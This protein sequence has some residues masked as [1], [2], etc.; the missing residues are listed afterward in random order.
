MYPVAC[1]PQAWASAAGFA[2]VQACLGLQFAPD[3]REIRFEHPMLP[4]FLD[5]LHIRGLRVGDAEADVRLHRSGN[6]IAATVA[7]RRGG[8]RVV[9]V[10]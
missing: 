3:T 4:K 5:Y 1:S 7:R 2:L 10:H 8:A 9:I 6:E